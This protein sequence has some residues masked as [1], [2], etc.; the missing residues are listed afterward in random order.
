MKPQSWRI[1]SLFILV[2]EGFGIRILDDVI[3]SP[4]S[5]W[6]ALLFIIN[7]RSIRKL[8]IMCWLIL[9]GFF[10]FYIVFSL[11][12]GV[13]PTFFLLAAWFSAFFVLSN[14]ADGTNSFEEDLYKFT[15]LCAIYSILHLP[16]IIIARNFLINIEFGLQMKTF[17]YVFYYTSSVNET[18]GLNRTQGFCWEPS[19]WNC[20]LNLNLALALSLNKSK[21][22]VSLC[23]AAI[24]FVFSTTGLATMFVV[25][26]LYLILY[27][28]KM[29]FS[30]IIIIVLIGVVV[31]PIA[32]NNFNNKL[33]SGSGA[34][35]YGDFFV[36]GYVIQT[37]P[38]L[39]A[40][41]NNIT[42]NAAAMEA[43]AEN[44]GRNAAQ[45]SLYDN[46]GMANAFAALFVEWGLFISLLLFYLMF[47]SPLFKTKKTAF[48]VSSTFLVV[49]MGTP[50][51]R[52]GFFYLFPLSSIIITNKIREMYY[53][54]HRTINS[55]NIV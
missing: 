22:E 13:S 30:T 46:V 17:M 26:G 47:K 2:F 52:T 54:K 16:I 41:L 50:I 21:K 32:R 39:G 44:W 36:A 23:V 4:I 31:A 53:T 25:F 34:T 12:K 40:D 10:A 29:T 5:F 35:R 43:K 9:F 37:S 42:S 51:A 14:Y 27:L 1:L 55:Q 7:F 6:T 18:L 20:L 15:K 49:L 33:D 3:P 19:C 28:K 48:V 24:F 38:L 11:L 8:P 45:L